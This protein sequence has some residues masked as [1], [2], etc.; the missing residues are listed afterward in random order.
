MC[1]HMLS[2]NKTLVNVKF[3]ARL[4]QTLAI[5]STNTS[6]QLE[7]DAHWLMVPAINVKARVGRVRFIHIDPTYASLFELL[8]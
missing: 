8:M 4:L 2:T 1:Y 6:I 7:L 5:H 3:A